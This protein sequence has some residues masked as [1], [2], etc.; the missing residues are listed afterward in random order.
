MINKYISIVIL[1]TIFFSG[2]SRTNVTYNAEINTNN[3]TQ[4]YENEQCSF[5]VGPINTTNELNIDS[6]VLD[7]IK[8]ANQDGLYGDKLI[9]I[10]VQKGGYTAILF[11]KY[12]L[13]I[14][15]NITYSKGL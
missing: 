4:F 1:T 5:F 6:L 9:N 10:K 12:C 7:T 8:Q 13:Y 11:S 15:G 14:Q 2:C 3:K